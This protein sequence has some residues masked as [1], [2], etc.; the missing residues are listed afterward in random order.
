MKA[1]GVVRRIDELGRIVIPKDIRKSLRLLEGDN[2]EIYVDDENITLKRFSLIKDM[3]NI[4]QNICDSIYTVLNKN[5]IVCDKNTIIA[6]SN[7]YKKQLLN[8]QISN[9]L[10]NYIKR[11]AE[12]D[13]NIALVDDIFIDMKYDMEYIIANGDILGLV[14]LIDSNIEEND[15]KMVKII[16]NFFGK[17]IEN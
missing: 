3:S 5:I 12:I 10:I 8:K 1:T 2:L 6:T 15:A 13:N 14:I 9:Y 7:P 4:A 16:G 17:Y 11:N